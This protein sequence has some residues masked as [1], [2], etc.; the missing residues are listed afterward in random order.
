MF[1]DRLKACFKKK[2][3]IKENQTKSNGPDLAARCVSD[4]SLSSLWGQLL[5][6]YF[7]FFL[8]FFFF[9]Q[10]ARTLF[11]DAREHRRFSFAAKKARLKRNRGIVKHS[12]G[13]NFKEGNKMLLVFSVGS[14]L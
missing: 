9:H 3:S 5:F 11:L 7:H 13:F 14:G 4:R 6:H 10:T 8:R 1:D 2:N 12:G